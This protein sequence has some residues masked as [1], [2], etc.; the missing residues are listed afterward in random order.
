MKC[1]YEEIGGCSGKVEIHKAMTSYHFKGE[2]NSP[3]DPNRDFLACEVH[4]EDYRLHWKEMWDEYYD[5]VAEG[6]AGGIARE[7]R[8]CILYEGTSYQDLFEDFA[9]RVK[10][11]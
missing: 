6:I 2:V 11:T 4:Y 10:F 3:E 5:I 8:S 7:E 1:E 9:S